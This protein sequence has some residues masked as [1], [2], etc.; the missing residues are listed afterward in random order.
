M[1]SLGNEAIAM[2]FHAAKFGVPVIAVMPIY[3]PISF[4]QRC[5]AMGAKVIVQG[6]TLYDAQ[7]YARAVARDKGLTY[8]NGCVLKTITDID[9]YW[10][11]HNYLS[12][13]LLNLIF[14]SRDHPDV[15]AGY[16]T[17]ALE[18]M[19]E[20]PEVEAIIVPIGTGGLAAATAR[21]VKHHKTNKCQVYVRIYVYIIR[22]YVEAVFYTYRSI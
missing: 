21:V 13:L 11:F 10:Y 19:H 17:I 2:C 8:I 20:I 12:L 1:A 14:Y 7:K 16:G 6:T 3:V 5:H 15:L 9:S 18:I 22:N 4:S